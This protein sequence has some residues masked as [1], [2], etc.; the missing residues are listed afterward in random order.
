M[1]S[2][3][4]REMTT[5]LFLKGPGTGLRLLKLVF[6]A[7]LLTKWIMYHLDTNMMH[8]SHHDLV[9]RQP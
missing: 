9:Q 3:P 1:H 4:I 7:G 8:M 6:P 5:S 2:C